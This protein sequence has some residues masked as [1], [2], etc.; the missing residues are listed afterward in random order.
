MTPKVSIVV[1]IYRVEKYL[2]ECV[3]SLLNQTLTNIEIVLVDDGS[4]DSCGEIAEQYACK[5]KRIKV[6]HQQNAGLGPARNAGI[7]VATGEYIGFV[8]SDDWVKPEMYEKLYEAAVRENADIAVSGHCDVENGKIKRKMRHPLAGKTLTDHADI[9]EVRKNLYGHRLFDDCIESFPMSVCM[10][11]YRRNMIEG[12]RLQFVNILSEDII[13]NLDAYKCAQIIAFM[14][15]TDY[16]YRKE[17][18]ESITYSFSSKKL[19]QFQE[20]LTFLTKKAM[21][22][23]DD[24]CIVRAK[25]TAIDYCRVYVGVVSRSKESVRNKKKYIREFIHNQTISSCWEGY[26]VKALPIQQGIFHVLIEHEFVGAALFLNLLRETL[27]K[28]KH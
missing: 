24:E 5:D 11:I 26:P 2:A 28:A 3:D 8:D 13:F 10:S 4:P 1:P 9:M 17:A 18:Q 6:I 20:F 25:R 21:Q 27:R 7:R 23:Q 22:E 19:M 12:R 15:S 16:C 14:D